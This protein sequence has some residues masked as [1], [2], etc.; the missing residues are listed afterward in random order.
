MSGKY[1]G[2]LFLI[3]VALFIIYF[4]TLL[5]YSNSAEIL[6]KQRRNMEN[7]L[8]S[9]V[10]SNI[11]MENEKIFFYFYYDQ[12]L[13]DY[14]KNF[15][16]YIRNKLEPKNIEFKNLFLIVEQ[17]TVNAGIEQEMNVSL[18]NLL[19]LEIS[20]INI[21]FTYDNSTKTFPSLEDGKILKTSFTFNITEDREYKIILSYY[22]GGN[23]THEIIIPFKVGRSKRIGF[24]SISLEIGDSV[25][26]EEIELIR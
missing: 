19:N 24:F 22:G 13:L 4:S 9:E 25:L 5:F 7:Y 2:Q 1:K 23:Q 11:K 17:P 18:L 12:R 14:I 6:L 20:S 15:T 10:L 3:T 16:F 8:Y 21:K 26:K